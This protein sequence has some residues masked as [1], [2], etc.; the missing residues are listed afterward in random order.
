MISAG[1]LRDSITFL[2]KDNARG[3]SGSQVS[4]WAESFT[5]RG[6]VSFQK[7][8]RAFEADAAWNPESVSILVRQDSRISIDMRL[9]W[10]TRDYFIEAINLDPLDRSVTIPATLI[11]E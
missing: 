7:G 11:N 8:S 4:Q 6:K 1:I 2:M 3:N 9:R 10:N 5:V